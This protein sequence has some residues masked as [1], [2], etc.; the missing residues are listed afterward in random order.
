ML[1]HAGAGF[2]AV[3]GDD[4]FEDRFVFPDLGGIV[5][6]GDGVLQGGVGRMEQLQEE[7]PESE[8]KDAGKKEKKKGNKK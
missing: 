3:A 2:G 7:Q 5:V 8:R 1:G 6:G 4:A